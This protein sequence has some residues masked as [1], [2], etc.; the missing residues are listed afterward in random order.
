MHLRKDPSTGHAAVEVLRP[1]AQV[2]LL[3][4][5][6]GEVSSVRRTCNSGTTR[7]DCCCGP[8]LRVGPGEPEQN[9]VKHGVLFPEATSACWSSP[10]QTE[11]GLRTAGNWLTKGASLRSASQRHNA[12]LAER[13]SGRPHRAMIGE[14]IVLPARAVENALKGI[15]M[16]RIGHWGPLTGKFPDVNTSSI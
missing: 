8:H 2:T 10:T 11:R 7:L 6:A 12:L 13:A 4:S 5:P 3:E 15:I 9:L 16:S 1:P 14:Q